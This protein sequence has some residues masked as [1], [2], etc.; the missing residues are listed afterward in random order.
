MAVPKEPTEE[1]S[2]HRKYIYVII[3][4]IIVVVAGYWYYSYTSTS[5]KYR[6]ILDDANVVPK[7]TNSTVTGEDDFTLSSDGNIMHFLYV[8]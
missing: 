1:Y 7:P 2:A 3:W 6:A 8:N 4:V 5:V